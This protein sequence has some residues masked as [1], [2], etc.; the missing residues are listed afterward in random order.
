MAK[1]NLN[2]MLEAFI[3]A[4]GV[5]PSL[6]RTPADETSKTAQTETR[7]E[8]CDGESQNSNTRGMAV[9]SHYS[10]RKSA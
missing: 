9:Y 3:L 10:G 1:L 8:R 5:P 7:N 4:A 2:C 6:W